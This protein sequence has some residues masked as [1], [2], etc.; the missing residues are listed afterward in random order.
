MKH[1]EW[2]AALT[3]VLV[4]AWLIYRTVTGF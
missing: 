2:K 1:G 3:Y 4:I